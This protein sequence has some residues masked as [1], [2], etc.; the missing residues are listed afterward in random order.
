MLANKHTLDLRIGYPIPSLS[1]IDAYNSNMILI[2][3]NNIEYVN[4]Y[5]C[6]SWNIVWQWW[7]S[8]VIVSAAKTSYLLMV[9]PKKDSESQSTFPL[10]WGNTYEQK[11]SLEHGRHG[12]AWH[13]QGL[14]LTLRQCA[15]QELL[16]RLKPKSLKLAQFPLEMQTSNLHLRFEKQN[17]INII[18]VDESWKEA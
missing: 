12:I 14:S 18:M 8:I 13:P 6:S 16:S 10:F 1:H 15:A 5:P 4:W 2:W 17:K 11:K 3:L 7:Y 9:P